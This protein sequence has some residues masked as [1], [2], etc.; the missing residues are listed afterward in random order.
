MIS[1]TRVGWQSFRLIPRAGVP[2][3]FF[4]LVFII[5]LFSLPSPAHSFDLTL[6]WDANTEPDL[7]GYKLYYKTGAAGPPYAG[8]GAAEGDSPIDVLDVTQFTIHG[9]D[10]GVTY[11]FV[12]TAYDTEDNESGYSNE[13]STSEAQTVSITSPQ[14]GFVVNTG[15]YTAYPI[16]GTAGASATV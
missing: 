12:V 10:I 11:H 1:H 9:L 16:S 15:T 5:T 3:F 6:E 2:S 7:A 14:D 13:V 8:M 4:C